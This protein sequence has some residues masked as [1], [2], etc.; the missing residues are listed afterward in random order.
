MIWHFDAVDLSATL[1]RLHYVLASMCPLASRW[2]AN[3]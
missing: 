2:K 3:I 1:S